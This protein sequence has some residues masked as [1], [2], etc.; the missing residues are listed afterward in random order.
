MPVGSQLKHIK[1][2]QP[3]A[4]WPAFNVHELQVGKDYGRPLANDRVTVSSLEVVPGGVAV[5]GEWTVNWSFVT[6]WK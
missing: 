5:N 2:S 1:L 4:L 6:A 3:L